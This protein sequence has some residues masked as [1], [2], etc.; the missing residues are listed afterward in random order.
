VYDSLNNLSNGKNKKHLEYDILYDLVKDMNFIH[1]DDYKKWA[2]I[3]NETETPETYFK[4]NEWV[5]YY[6]FLKINID[7]YPKTIE[8]LKEKCISNNIKSKQDYENKMVKLN[9]PSM[10]DELYGKYLSFDNDEISI[11]EIVNY[12]TEEEL[13]EKIT[14][15]KIKKC[16]L[17]DEVINN[18]YYTHNNLLKYI[19]EKFLVNIQKQNVNAFVALKNLIK[20]INEKKCSFELQ[21]DSNSKILNF[22]ISKLQLQY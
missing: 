17:N 11:N 5:N 19:Q 20:L 7:I 13:F 10:P 15:S 16:I 12:L 18:K 9:M 6:K 4:N 2:N 22:K 21:I 8:E 3:N 1:K 14:F